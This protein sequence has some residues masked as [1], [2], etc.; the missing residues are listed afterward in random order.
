MEVLKMSSLKR[1]KLCE[2]TEKI[3]VLMKFLFKNVNQLKTF[4]HYLIA[5]P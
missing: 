1:L 5:I 2:K 4:F 3:A